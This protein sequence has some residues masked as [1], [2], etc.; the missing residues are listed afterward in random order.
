MLKQRCLVCGKYLKFI[1][2]E[3]GD[4][5]FGRFIC[6]CGLIYVYGL[7]EDVIA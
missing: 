7:T 2:Y 6:K 1:E 4:K 3:Q 5:R